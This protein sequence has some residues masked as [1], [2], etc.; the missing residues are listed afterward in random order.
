MMDW[1]WER[2]GGDD[3]VV[4]GGRQRHIADYL[5]AMTDDQAMGKHREYF[6]SSFQ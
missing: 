4:E 5:A 6:G 3:R 1:Y 2:S